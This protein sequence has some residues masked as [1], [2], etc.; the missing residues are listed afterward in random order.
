MHTCKYEAIWSFMMGRSE[1]VSE[2]TNI[3]KAA[4]SKPI[5]NKLKEKIVLL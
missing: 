1:K 4:K 3:Y 5:G 2:E